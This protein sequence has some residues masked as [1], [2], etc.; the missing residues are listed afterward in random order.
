MPGPQRVVGGEARG[1]GRVASASS[2]AA[3]ETRNLSVT[4]D[5]ADQPVLD[6]IDLEVRAGEFIAIVGASGSGKTTLLRAIDGLVKP[7]SGAVYV[8]GTEVDRPG[9]DRAFVFQ[10]DNLLPWRTIRDNVAF[11]LEIQGMAREERHRKAEE[12]LRLTGLTGVEDRFP[13]QLSGGMRQRVNVARAFAVN[14]DVLLMDEPFAALD[15]Q[16]R[17]VLQSELLSIW[18][19]EKKTVLFVTHQLDEA[20]YLADR[21]VVLSSNPG[22]IREIVPIELPRPRE[23][24]AKHTKEFSDLETHLWELIKG[25]VLS[26]KRI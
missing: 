11:G 6:A 23:L 8:R 9:P 4:F 19:R 10:Q 12:M 17:E 15:A 26:E 25:E 1:H 20:V 18:A 5:A 21:V 22:R 14:P 24:D 7:S 2:P 13:A 3:I 16:T